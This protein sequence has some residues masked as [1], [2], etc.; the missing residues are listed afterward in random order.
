MAGFILCRTEY[1]KRPYYINN[2]AINIFS[3]EELCYYIYNNIY[4]VGTDLFDDGLIDFINH[5]LGDEQLAK[6]LEFLVSQNAG[7]SE[8]VLT[9]LRYV[10][11]YSEREIEALKSTI[12]KLDTQNVSERLKSRADNFLSNNRFGSAI[13]NYETILYGKRDAAQKDAFY[14]DVWHNMGVAYALA[15][16]FEEAKRCFGNAFA[17]NKREESYMAMLSAT[18]MK[19]NVP[20]QEMEEDEQMYVAYREIEA[21]MDHAPEAIEYQPIKKAL[22]MKLNG[23]IPEYNAAMSD[24]V[25]QWKTDYRNYIR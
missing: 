4:L 18:C 16:E 13:R 1:A 8:L 10:D 23:Q 21:L 7:L 12:D 17:L 15:F 3:L 22:I 2:M 9:M 11:Y 6:Q 19:Q 5:E 20:I 25:K 14:G 24:I